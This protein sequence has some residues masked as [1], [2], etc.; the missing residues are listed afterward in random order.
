MTKVTNLA[1]FS[2][3]LLKQ[4]QP[5]KFS[6]LENGKNT[7]NSVEMKSSVDHYMSLFIDQNTQITH[8][9]CMISQTILRHPN[10]DKPG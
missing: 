4:M 5:D 8:S 9:N 7:V 10:Y 2:H 6:Q 3:G 1:R